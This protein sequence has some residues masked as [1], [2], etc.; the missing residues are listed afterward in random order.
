MKFN[1]L[2]TTG[3]GIFETIFQ[4][5][6]PDDFS[7]I[8]GDTLAKSLDLQATML[9]GNRLLLDAVTTETYRDIVTSVISMNVSNWVK[10]AK[11]MNSE[12]DVLKPVIHEINRTETRTTDET[13]ESENTTSEKVYNDTEFN[14]NNKEHGTGTN[15]KTET[16][17]VTDT[18]SGIGSNKNISETIQKEMM[19]RAINW[20][21]NI[22]FALV[23][24]ITIDIYE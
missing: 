21:K 17:T 4:P 2:F 7:Q 19:L 11:T 24:E 20:K 6:F 22:I 23:K 3:N 1:E 12:Y 8:F 10:Q 18:E 14:E 13:N 5:D 15:N 9:Y 16:V